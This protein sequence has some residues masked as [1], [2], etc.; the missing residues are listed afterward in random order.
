MQKTIRYIEYMCRYCGK[1]E[2]KGKEFG[3]PSPGKCPRR[4][5]MPH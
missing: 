2:R 4:N 3:R 1:R 5:N